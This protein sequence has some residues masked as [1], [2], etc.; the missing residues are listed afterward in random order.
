MFIHTAFLTYS[1]FHCIVKQMDIIPNHRT[2]SAISEELEFSITQ[3][4][5]SWVKGTYCLLVFD[6]C[7][8]LRIN[9]QGIF[10]IEE[11]SRDSEFSTWG[12]QRLA[13][14]LV[15]LVSFC[16][17]RGILKFLTIIII[18]V[19]SLLRYIFYILRN[20][21]HLRIYIASPCAGLSQLL[22]HF[23]RIQNSDAM[24]ARDAVLHIFHTK[25]RI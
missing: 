14:P 13:Y 17:N 19:Y 22:C 15:L 4:S 20:D 6:P 25:R 11:S 21:L 18:K 23:L 9:C 7:R 8:T 10:S 24:Q 3:L 1:I 12:N 2:L 5:N 16:V